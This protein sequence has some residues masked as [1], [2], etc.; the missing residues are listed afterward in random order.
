MVRRD[1]GSGWKSIL[2]EEKWK[3]DGR[4][5]LWRENLEGNI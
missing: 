1:W 4:W 5:G 3:E 2:I